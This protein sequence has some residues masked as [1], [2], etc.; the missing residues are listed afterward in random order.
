M[1]GGRGREEIVLQSNVQGPGVYWFL[2][3]HGDIAGKG[4]VIAKGS[5][6]CD[7]ALGRLK[8]AVFQLERCAA[9]AEGQF[10]IFQSLLLQRQFV[11]PHIQL[12]LGVALKG[13]V[14]CFR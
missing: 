5:R 9:E 6:Q 4:H 7:T 11:F 13:K 12:V 10:L 8:T 1:C 2:R 3:L 14:H